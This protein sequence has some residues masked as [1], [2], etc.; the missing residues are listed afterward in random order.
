MASEFRLDKTAF[1]VVPLHDNSDEKQ[2]WLSKTREERL[3]AVEYLRQM[4]YGYDPATTRL[5][6]VLEVVKRTSG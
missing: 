6:R 2:Y 4:A 5:Q 3:E 1:S